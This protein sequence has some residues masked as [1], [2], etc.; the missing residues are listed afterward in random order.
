MGPTRA[1]STWF[2]VSLQYDRMNVTVS[3]PFLVGTA[4]ARHG[5][6]M[7]GA[8]AHLEYR[9]AHQGWRAARAAY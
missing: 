5:I 1:L 6:A 4:D 2:C 7:A 9:I 8:A 3:L